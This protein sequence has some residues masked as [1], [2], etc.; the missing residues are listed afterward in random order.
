MTGSVFALSDNKIIAAFSRRGAGNMSLSYGDTKLS[1]DN[2]KRF[3]S[4]LGID[5]KALVCAKQTHSGN[6]A[7]VDINQR[8][9]GAVVYA[10]ALD[11][12]DALITAE[13]NLPLAV[14]TA[15]CLSVFL[16]DPATPAVGM[17]HAGWRS[18]LANI[19]SSAVRLMRKK[20]GSKAALL[21]AGFGPS[22]K[23]CCN[24]IDADVRGK[25]SFGV[26]ERG[27]GA[28][29]DLSDVNIKQLFDEGVVP[30]NIS[31]A[32]GCTNCCGDEFFSF[33][34]EKEACGRMISVIMLK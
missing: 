26:I 22:I 11:D 9:Q 17:V 23:E 25:F 34:R 18:S 8:G 4:D 16:Y 1:L 20:F 2:R 13:I 19:T 7:C 28:Y 31:A 5:Y 6:V 21:R 32:A 29:L 12:C 15:D 33:R 27:G 3:L 30:A 14:F 10:T 24:K